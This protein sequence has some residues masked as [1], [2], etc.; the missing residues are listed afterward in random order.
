[1]FSSSTAVREN[2]G[3]WPCYCAP[4][5]RAWTKNVGLTETAVR[6]Q[7]A[8]VRPR[9]GERAHEFPIPRQKGKPAVIIT[10]RTTPRPFNFLL[11]Q[12]RGAIRAV[13]AVLGYGGYKFIGKLLKPGSKH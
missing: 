11:S 1:M 4:R 10:A 7:R 5:L 6:P 3:Q 13:G 12:G 8:G 9:T 2:T